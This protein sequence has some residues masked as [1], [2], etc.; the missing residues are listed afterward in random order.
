MGN[1]KKL[2]EEIEK[3]ETEQ[4]IKKLKPIP[5]F[6]DHGGTCKGHANFMLDC[7]Y[8]E[9]EDR[10]ALSRILSRYISPKKNATT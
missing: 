2:N 7:T 1:I 4:K 3:K 9:Q 6:N 10:D 8:E 5:R